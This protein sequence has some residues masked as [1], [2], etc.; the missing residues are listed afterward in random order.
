MVSVPANIP[1][2]AQEGR[3]IDVDQQPL[4]VMR[5]TDVNRHSHTDNIVRDTI[6]MFLLHLITLNLTCQI[7][8]KG[9]IGSTAYDEKQQDIRKAFFGGITEPLPDSDVRAHD[10]VTDEENIIE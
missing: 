5:V 1:Q 7:R 3:P 6:A 4:L 10:K 2:G 9:G 8:Q